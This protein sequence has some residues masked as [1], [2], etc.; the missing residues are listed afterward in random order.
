MVNPEA[1]SISESVVKPSG[2]SFWRRLF[3]KTMKK[4]GVV[5]I[6]DPWHKG[7]PRPV[8]RTD[9]GRLKTIAENGEGEWGEYDIREIDALRNFRRLFRRK[10]K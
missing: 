6:A 7:D 10:S 3:N 5:F 8:I 1:A 9:D 2:L 4:V